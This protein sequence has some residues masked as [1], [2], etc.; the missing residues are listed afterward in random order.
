MK[1][2]F[3]GIDLPE[4]KTKY[5]D[6]K[7]I[8]LEAKDKAKKV[9]PFFAEFIKD[10]FVQTEAIVV[11]KSNILDLLILDMDKIETRLS[12]LEDGVEKTLMTRCMELL[13]QETPLCDV[14]FNDEENELLIATA[15]I[16]FKPVVQIEGSED[17][18]TMIFSAL[19]KANYMFFYTSGP[20]EAHAW[21][22]Q[23]GSEIVAC[24][25]KIHSDLA[26]GFIKGD[27]V[28]FEDYMNCH[29]FNDCKSKG[30]AKLVDRDYILQPN[31]IIEIR[32]N[33]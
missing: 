15:P 17:I 16:S 8:A 10:E 1:I 33:V 2:G 4:G 21:L 20:K 14:D 29:N 5:N 11:P 9:A 30:V 27:V 6:E 12:K 13:E 26:R 31:N 18:N 32:F 3:T 24:A 28:S 22:V 7:L 23:K 25:E 19:E